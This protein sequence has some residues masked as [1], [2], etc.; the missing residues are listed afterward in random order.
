MKSVTFSLFDD[1]IDDNN[2][3]RKIAEKIQSKDP[4]INKVEE[5]SEIKKKIT[6]KLDEVP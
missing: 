2:T 6:V 4:S 3:K 5:E 1:R